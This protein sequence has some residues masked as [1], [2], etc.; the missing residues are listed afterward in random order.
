MRRMPEV[1]INQDYLMHR[2]DDAGTHSKI[3]RKDP[4]KRKKEIEEK[5]RMKEL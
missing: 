3:K 4:E 1:R 2:Y 5:K